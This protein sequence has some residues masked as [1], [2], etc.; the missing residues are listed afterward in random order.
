[1][2]L[3]RASLRHVSKHAYILRY[4]KMLMSIQIPLQVNTQSYTYIHVCRWIKFDCTPWGWNETVIHMYYTKR[5]LPGLH[6]CIMGVKALSP[7]K[8]RPT[9]LCTL[10]AQTHTR[11]PVNTY[12]QHWKTSVASHRQF[13]NNAAWIAFYISLGTNHH[14]GTSSSKHY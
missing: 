12:M 4:L 8:L 7:V 1:M 5:L 9:H 6:S 11:L 14:R 2:K 10:F 3:V 13:E